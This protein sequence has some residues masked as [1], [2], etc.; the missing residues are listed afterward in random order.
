M[1]VWNGV[2]LPEVM[3]GHHKV[4]SELGQGAFGIT[5][6]LVTDKATNEKC[7]AKVMDPSRSRSI[8]SRSAIT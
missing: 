7:V 4:E 3:R 8:A 5:W 1:S 6:L 2:E